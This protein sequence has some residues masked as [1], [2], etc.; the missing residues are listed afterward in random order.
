M[1]QLNDIRVASIA[2]LLGVDPSSMTTNEFVIEWLR[3]NGAPADNDSIVDCWDGMLD[4][5]L[6]PPVAG[7]RND[8]WLALLAQQGFDAKQLNDAE[9]SFWSAGGI[10]A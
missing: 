3:L 8:R 6:S 7:K 10:I 5:Q 2:A 1:T 4:A 9:H